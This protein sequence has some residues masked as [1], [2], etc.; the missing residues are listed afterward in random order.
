MLWAYELSRKWDSMGSFGVRGDFK[1]YR[2]RREGREGRVN[3]LG[4]RP[5]A[6]NA[7]GVE[8][9]CDQVLANSSM[10]TWPLTKSAAY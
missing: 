10:G 8:R 2:G 9:P 1:A 6:I 3:L 4:I 5:Q 7:L